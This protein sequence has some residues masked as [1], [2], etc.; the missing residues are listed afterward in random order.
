ML[1]NL[2]TSGVTRGWLARCF[3][4][5]LMVSGAAHSAPAFGA[6]LS[7]VQLERALSKPIGITWAGQSLRNGLRTV[8]AEYQ[9]AV[10]LDRRVDPSRKVDLSVQDM[11]LR[12]ALA[13]IAHDQELGH[14]WLGPV[15]YYGPIE[16]ARRLRTLAALRKE[17]VQKLPAQAR[18]TLARERRLAW[19]ELSTPQDVLAD[20]ATTYK[21]T[22]V[23]ADEVPH[24]LWPAGN[25]PALSF[26]EQ[27]TLMIAGFDLTFRLDQTGTQVQLIPMPERVTIDRLYP[28]D[29]ADPAELARLYGRTVPDAQVKD[30]RGQVAVRGRLEDHEKIAALRRGESVA[31]A[32][33]PR[34]RDKKKIYTYTLKVA[35][36]IE[37]LLAALQRQAKFEL[38]LNR[39]AIEAAELDMQKVVEID[40]K[41]VSLDELLEAALRPAGLQHRRQGTQVEV[42]PRPK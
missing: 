2:N 1:R 27:L 18:Q 21:L 33:A 37:Q 4:L 24:D 15:A 13:R 28:V 17:E 19:S 5:G 42:F 8:Q 40:V 12:E 26:A 23:N 11:A 3:F 29:G 32:P 38:A 31:V 30:F 7:G 25:L 9:V 22:I 10:H 39:P 36:P 41:D 34:P 20:V 16:T 6:L 14:I 35:A